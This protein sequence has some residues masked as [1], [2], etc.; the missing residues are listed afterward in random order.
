MSEPTRPLPPLSELDTAP[1]W[2]RTA[3]DRLSYPRCRSCATIVFYPRRHCSGCGGTDLEWLDASG[4]G[5]I[6]TFSVIRQSYHPFFRGR[7]PYAV[8][9]IDLDEGPRILSNVVEVEDPAESLAI[10]QRVTLV[11]EAHE[12][13]QIPLFRPV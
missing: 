4:Q 10:G 7:V 13:L 5:T 1:F 9:W 3:E 6:Y 2:A 8:A 11:W 12:A